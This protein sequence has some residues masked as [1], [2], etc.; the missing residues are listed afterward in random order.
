M[1]NLID[2]NY[3]D[4]IV[5]LYVSE[6]STQDIKMDISIF[7]EAMLH[8]SARKRKTYDRLEFL[9][10]AVYHIVISEYIF[11]RYDSE[12]EGF[13]TKLRI[14]LERGESM[15]ELSYI[16]LLDRYVQLNNFQLNDHIMEDIFEAFIG[17]FF[18]NFGMKYVRVLIISLI[19]QHKDVAEMIVHD[20]NYKDL[21]LRY[22]H[23]L[24]WG[25]PKYEETYIDNKYVS[26]VRNPDGQIIGKGASRIKRTAEQLASKSVLEK[27]KIIVDD[28]VDPNWMD[29][30]EKIEKV[31]KIDKKTLPIHN[32]QNKLLSEK[33][34]FKMLNDC[35]IVVTRGTKL[36]LRRFNEAM[37]HRSYLSRTKKT[38]DKKIPVD[39][40]CVP[41]QKKSNCRLQF[42]GG[43]VLH[44]VVTYMLFKKYDVEDE[45]FLTRLR[46][47]LENK[48]VLFYLAQQTDIASYVMVS[49]NIEMLHGR[50][51]I[52][53]IGG[54]F[55][56]FIGA[57]YLEMDL[58]VTNDFV[59]TT[60]E[61]NYDIDAIAQDETNHKEVIY[62]YFNRK[63]WSHPVYQLI[64]ESGPDHN[65]IFEIALCRPNSDD[66]WT[67]GTGSSKRK[68]EQNASK[69]AYQEIQERNQK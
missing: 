9:G 22:F 53:I 48:E 42:L 11:I 56:A 37:T 44:F 15:T 12:N 69:Q 59:L 35:N 38:T 36:K 2:Y 49:Q 57:L 18:L 20:D 66:I 8:N 45:G 7:R 62:H 6:L 28:K 50:N 46:S 43:A 24:K 47:K 23:Q 31:K 4:R 10:D 68:A 65:K 26:V 30:I 54:G 14:R 64:K 61:T 25:H 39:K 40:L 16:L 63:G 1:S 67:T 13:L 58:K 19:E 55:E 3:V 21:L 52:N 51:N 41:L 27:M 32:S 34:I 60:Y 5:K 17:A 33:I 29:H